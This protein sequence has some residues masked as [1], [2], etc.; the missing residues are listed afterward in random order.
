LRGEPQV[1]ERETVLGHQPSNATAE[2][3]AR[4]TG[5]ANDTSRR[6][7]AVHLRLTIELLPQDATLGSCSRRPHV[8]VNSLHERQVDQQAS[9]ERRMSGHVVAAATDGDGEIERSCELH[10]GDNVGD[11]ATA[12]DRGW[13][14]VDQTVVHPAPFVVARV[15]GLEQLSR[16]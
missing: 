11:T 16:E 3:Q 7:E 6:C 2:S 14:L 12:S 4:D 9:I 10:R 8:H 15:G 1:V 13:M 5:A